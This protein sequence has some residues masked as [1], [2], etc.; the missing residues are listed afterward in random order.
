[1]L[2]RAR[3]FLTHLCWL[4]LVLE[5]LQQLCLTG[6]STVCDVLFCLTHGLPCALLH[7]I[8]LSTFFRKDS[9]CSVDFSYVLVIDKQYLYKMIQ[10]GV[11]EN[12]TSFLCIRPHEK[13]KSLPSLRGTVWVFK[14]LSVLCIKNAVTIIFVLVQVLCIFFNV[15]SNNP[16]LMCCCLSYFSFLR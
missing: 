12:T 2:S 8:S 6:F 15:L 11:Q 7:Q 4:D 10:V 13:K 5:W 14:A 9:E 1:M 16:D 3:K